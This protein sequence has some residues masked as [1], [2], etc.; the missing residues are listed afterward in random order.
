VD[1]QQRKDGRCRGEVGHDQQAAPPDA[2]DEHPGG[3]RRELRKRD[4]ED[5]QARGAAG[6]GQLLGPDTQRQPHRRVTEQ[7]QRLAG[8]VQP[9]VAAGEQAPHQ[10]TRSPGR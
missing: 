4:R 10:S 2:I 5:D 9:R 7:R 1:R 3:R 8:E 6:P